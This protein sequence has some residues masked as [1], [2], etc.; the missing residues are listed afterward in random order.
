MNSD[1]TPDSAVPATPGF[2]PPTQDPNPSLIGT[3]YLSVHVVTARGAIPLSGA[4]VIIRSDDEQNSQPEG[5]IIA[6]LHT[7][8]DDN[9]R[10]YPLPTCSRSASLTPGNQK[11]YTAYRVDV[12]MLHY[13]AT[14]FVGVP[15]FDGVTSLQPVNLIPAPEDGR[16]ISEGKT[17][18]IESTAAQV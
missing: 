12:S 13:S 6:I 11:P 1:F 18:I 5:Q 3:G 14:T 9:T 16:N 17:V 4:S 8:A 15:I 10:T 2:Q 7:D